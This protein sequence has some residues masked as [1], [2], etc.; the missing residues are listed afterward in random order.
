MSVLRNRRGVAAL[1]TVL[2]FLA[3]LTIAAV[4]T[5]F[6][7]MQVMRLELQTAADAAA[8]AGAKQLLLSPQ[9]DAVVKAQLYGGS[10]KVLG[11]SVSIA[12]DDVTY[13]KWNPATRVFTGGASPTTADA[14]QVILRRPASYL[15]ANTLGWR[16]KNIAVRAIAWAGPSV[17]KT[18]CMKP[19]A[20]PYQ[21]LM[22][23]INTHEGTSSDPTRA[24]TPADLQA[25]RDMSTLERTFSLFLGNSKTQPLGS[26]TSGG[27][28]YAV[29][30]PP[31]QYANGTPGTPLTGGSAYSDALAGVDKNGNPI[32]YT[33]SVGDVLQTEPGAMIGPTRQGVSPAICAT[34]QADNTCLGKDGK[35]P[36]IKSAFW[37]TATDKGNGKYNVVVKVIGSFVLQKFNNQNATITGVFQPID[38]A[39]PSGTET[40][41]LV[42]LVLVK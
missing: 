36:L 38:D 41:T 3:M 25:L 2:V 42:K 14:I 4:V 19:W 22:T 26:P 16:N 33:V 18:D 20:M 9:S 17:A 15:M 10:N 7:R 28:Y 31:V 24:M 11:Q 5:D 32:C 21:V 29:D 34:I 40:T 27:N 37:L 1:F 23:A 12:A 13:G 6:S 30:L 8:L 39:G 35:S